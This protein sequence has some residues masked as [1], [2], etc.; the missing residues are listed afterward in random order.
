MVSW[1]HFVTAPISYSIAR[2]TSSSF[3][4]RRAC[5]ILGTITVADEDIPDSARKPKKDGDEDEGKPKK[6]APAKKAP[7]K[8]AEEN[9]DDDDDAAEPEE[10][11]KPKK[12]R[13]VGFGA[14]LV[15][16]ICVDDTKHDL[17]SSANAL[18]DIHTATKE[19]EG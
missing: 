7:K 19:E 6:K 18:L 14:I 9:G 17:L 16:D 10:E 4:I 3:I 15:S 2:S 12:K 5:W 11:E 8:K 1:E 13:G